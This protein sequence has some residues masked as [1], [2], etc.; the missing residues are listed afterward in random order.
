MLHITYKLSS[1]ISEIRKYD[2]EEYS[3][4]DGVG[5]DG[6]VFVVQTNSNDVG[7]LGGGIGYFGIDQSVG[8]EFDTYDNGPGLGDPDGNHVAINTSG[9]LAG[10]LDVEPVATRMNEGDIWYAWVDY[11]GVTKDLEV[12]LGDSTTRPASP[13]VE[14]N[15][16]LPLILG[17]TTAFVGFTS[18]TG[19][20]YG[21]HDI[22]SWQFRDN[23]EPIVTPPPTNGVPEA[24][25]GII[26]MLLGLGGLTVFRRFASKS[27]VA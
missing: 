23:F 9:S 18:G 17:N 26:A 5:A 13:F 6:L 24:G 12:R 10:P 16:D 14:A 4:G 21:D 22:L 3:D 19:G 1:H 7:S 8:I 27:K 2:A 11:N 20:A 15:V 25:S